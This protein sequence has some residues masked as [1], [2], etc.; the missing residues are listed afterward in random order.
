MP[1]GS[2]PGPAAAA[3]ARKAFDLL[4]GAA[5]AGFE[6]IVAKVEALRGRPVLIREEPRLAG[7]DA[8]SVWLSTPEAE[9]V[10]HAPTESALHR[11]QCVLHSLSHMVLQ[12]SE[13]DVPSGVLRGLFP[14]LSEQ[15][16]R[17]ALS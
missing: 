8:A 4:I 2:D 12:S 14:D 13:G 10:M 1:A 3:A 7:T 5:D 11:Q 16:V 9:I 6:S 17:A 15:R